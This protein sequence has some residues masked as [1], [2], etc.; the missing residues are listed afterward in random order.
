MIF[1]GISTLND[2]HFVRA[3]VRMLSCWGVVEVLVDA[4]LR[5]SR[6][7]TSSLLLWVLLL[8]LLRVA[9]A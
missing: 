1:V 4:D 8:V 5:L 3:S 6:S 2:V 7:F 9:Q